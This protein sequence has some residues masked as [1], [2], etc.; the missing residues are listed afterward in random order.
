VLAQLTLLKS[1]CINFR[2]GPDNINRGRRGVGQGGWGSTLSVGLPSIHTPMV[3]YISAI[4][5]KRER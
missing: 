2:D 5:S 1:E 4:R 3:C